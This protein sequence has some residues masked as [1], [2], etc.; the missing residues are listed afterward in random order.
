MKGS[1]FSTALLSCAI[2]SGLALPLAAFGSKVVEVDFQKEPLFSGQLR[3]IAVPYLGAAGLISLG[4]GAIGLSIAGWRTS[5]QKSSEIAGRLSQIQDELKTKQSQIE[6]FQMSEPYLKATGLKE[7]LGASAVQALEP[8]MPSATE[9]TCVTVSASVTPLYVAG[10]A[11]AWATPPQAVAAE[12]SVEPVEVVSSAS[13]TTIAQESS[14]VGSAIAVMSQF[15]ELQSQLQHMA[16][17]VEK[18]QTSLDSSKV[19]VPSVEP[20]K[21]ELSKIEPA[22]IKSAYVGH[23]QPADSNVIE[24]LHRRLQQLESDWVRQKVAL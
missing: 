17:Q 11:S 13:Q 24:H 23:S 6:E 1:L 3:D 14:S 2:F 9:E 22:P 19:E 21:V 5:S 15:Q 7:F 10:A 16:A 8:A 20:A 4:A 12:V 18:L